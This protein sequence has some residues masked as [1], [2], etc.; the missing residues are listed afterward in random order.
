MT[1]MD[2]E[3]IAWLSTSGLTDRNKEAVFLRSE[4]RTL[5]AVGVILGVSPERIRQMCSKAERLFAMR[6]RAAERRAALYA[7]ENAR[8]EYW[9]K[10]RSLPWALLTAD[11]LE[12]SA[13]AYN[14]MQNEGWTL[15]DISKATDWE[16]LRV[17]NCGRKTLRELRNAVAKAAS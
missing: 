1:P 6:H 10:T 17:P 5:R 12:L 2:K 14:V 13:R 15:G 9:G 3:F 8:R 7:A 4:G 16:I 11:C